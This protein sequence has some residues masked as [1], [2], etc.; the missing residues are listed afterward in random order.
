MRYLNFALPTIALGLALGVVLSLIPASAANAPLRA[1]VL[2]AHPETLL[3]TALDDLQA[4]RASEAWTILDRL[5]KRQPNF[6][7]AQ[8]FYGELLAARSGAPARALLVSSNEPEVKELVEEARL[9]L[10]QWRQAPP[11][12]TAPD[13][14]LRLSPAQTHAVV[15]DL[16]RARL[17]LMENTA[18]G[19][20]VTK[21][22][23][24]PSCRCESAFQ[25]A[26]W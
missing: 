24:A 4:G 11:P 16:T 26:W 18:N 22:Y 21:N 8:L 3:L 20:R 6:R 14:I 1:A 25:P 23:Y 9:R 2:D 5:V 19:L 12:G 15:V 17:Y 7:L 13:A 10:R